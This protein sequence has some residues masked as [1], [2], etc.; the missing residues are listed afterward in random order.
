MAGDSTSAW[1]NSAAW[2]P[3]QFGISHPAESVPFL[4]WLAPAALGI[5]LLLC[6]RGFAGEPLPPPERLAQLGTQNGYLVW[7][8]VWSPLWSFPAVVTMLALRWVLIVRGWFGW[9]SALV[10][11]AV[12]GIAVPVLLGRNFVL[13]GPLYGAAALWMQQAVY[14]ARYPDSFD[15]QAED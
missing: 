7:T 2:R 5:L 8:L 15:G 13:A 3:P 14:R 6:L 9:G 4:I 11:G 10:A 1:R 12:S